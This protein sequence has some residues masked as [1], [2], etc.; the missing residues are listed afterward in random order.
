M[1]EIF[2]LI[3]L[4]QHDSKPASWWT[5]LWF[6]SD[7]NTAARFPLRDH[8]ETALKR[9]EVSNEI[10][11][12]LLC[13]T[14]HSWTPPPDA[15]APRGL[16][17]KPVDRAMVERSRAAFARGEGK[18]IDEVIA[19]LEGSPD[20]AAPDGE[21]GIDPG[22]A[23]EVRILQAGGVETT[24]SCQGG[25][26]HSF[27]EPTVRFHGGQSEGPR[28][29]GIALQN[30][31]RVT[32]LRRVWSII[33]G[34]MV[35]PGWE[36]VFHHSGSGAVAVEKEDGTVTWKWQHDAAPAGVDEGRLRELAGKA[37]PGPW[38]WD[39]YDRVKSEPASRRHY[40]WC[41]ANGLRTG[42]NTDGFTDADWKRLAA[43]EPNTTVLMIPKQRRNEGAEQRVNDAFYLEAANP[44]TVLSLLDRLAA[45][46]AERDQSRKA[47][48][49][50]VGLAKR[51]RA[52]ETGVEA[53]RDAA[54]ARA[55]AAER[56]RDKWIAGTTE[57]KQEIAWLKADNTLHRDK[58]EGNYWAWQG[59][60][61]DHLESLVSP[62]L[63]PAKAL[64][65]ILDDRD[66]ACRRLAA[67]PDAGVTG[68]GNE[69]GGIGP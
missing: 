61:E 5:G 25:Q 48:K 46:R 24:E 52:R 34:E 65:K 59:N 40:E 4:R 54:L 30:G 12:T 14:E 41:K 21:R 26:G 37:T 43:E 13:V 49:A 55:D 22:I 50:C 69:G 16:R 38:F 23:H 45:V 32:T 8:A 56:D 33:D 53:E 17:R 66:T 58:A 67:A 11:R 18:S 10:D 36:M 62:V 63:I 20:A 39:S 64:K 7:A 2:Y 9:L 3:E 19:D 60:D 57:L 1:V 51:F 42:D 15:A 35:G 27:P 68:G 28:A 6:S 29:L 31:L 47:F 44:Q